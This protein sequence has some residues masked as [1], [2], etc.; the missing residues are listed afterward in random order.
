ME[1]ASNTI[2]MQLTILA[3]AKRT[4]RTDPAWE[5]VQINTL[6]VRS[7]RAVDAERQVEG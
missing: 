1:L 4:R 5:Q 2:N 6:L 7:A 3:F